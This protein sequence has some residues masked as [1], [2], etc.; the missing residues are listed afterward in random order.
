MSLGLFGVSPTFSAIAKQFL[1]AQHG[2]HGEVSQPTLIMAGEAG[3]R[4]RV[5]ISPFDA[6]TSGASGGNAGATSRIVNLNL[7]FTGP[8]LGDRFQAQQLVQWILPE[9]RRATA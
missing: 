6:M 8:V 2:L 4:E 1:H 7:T 9:L 3:R 5:D